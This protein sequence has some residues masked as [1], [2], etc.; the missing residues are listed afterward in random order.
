MRIPNADRAII[1][2]E[3]LRFY[4]LNPSHRRGSAKARLLPAADIRLRH[5]VSWNP[6]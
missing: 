6:I 4:L 2:P 3:K 5:G 1:A